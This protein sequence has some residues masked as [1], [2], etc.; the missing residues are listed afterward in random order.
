MRELVGEDGVE[1]GVVAG[2]EQ[3]RRDDDRPA[4]R[5]GDRAAVRRLA[6][7]DGQPRRRGVEPRARRSRR[8]WSSGYDSRS[9]TRAPVPAR[10]SVRT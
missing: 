6:V 8:P 7:D 1:F 3:A 2:V 4:A 5:A 9:T 10:R